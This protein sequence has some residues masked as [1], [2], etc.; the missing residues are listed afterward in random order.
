VR[1]LEAAI[2][3]AAAMAGDSELD[4]AHLPRSVTGPQHARRDSAASPDSTDA[5]SAEGPRTSP[6]A[7]GGGPS[8]EALRQ[9]LARHR[10]NVAAVARELGK[11]RAQIHRW[12]RYA[13]IDPGE[14]R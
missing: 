13:S 5:R 4:V 3:H 14:Y 10:G 1:E 8:P 12:L 11:D 6:H 9:L 7:G 2:R